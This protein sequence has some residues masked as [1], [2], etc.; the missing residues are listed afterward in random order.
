MVIGG[1]KFAIGGSNDKPDK[2]VAAN[3]VAGQWYDYRFDSIE[4]VGYH[5]LLSADCAIKIAMRV[6]TPKLGVLIAC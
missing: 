3:E 2:H 6:W 1:T 5:R 4:V